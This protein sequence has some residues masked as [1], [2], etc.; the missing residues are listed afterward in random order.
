MLQD[1]LGSFLYRENR[2]THNIIAQHAI[3]AI[4]Q[5][6]QRSGNRLILRAYPIFFKHQPLEQE[7]LTVARDSTFFQT[8]GWVEPFEFVIG[9]TIRYGTI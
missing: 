9:D 4:N 2:N 6:F 3:T 5:I 1:K 8:T 7:H